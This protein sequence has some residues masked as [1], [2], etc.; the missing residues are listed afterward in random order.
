MAGTLNGNI[1]KPRLLDVDIRLVK[2]PDS[3]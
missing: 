1:A 3:E 2:T